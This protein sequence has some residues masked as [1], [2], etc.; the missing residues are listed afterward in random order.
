LIFNIEINR[1]EKNKKQQTTI[2]E[3]HK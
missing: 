1:Q 3:I 2:E